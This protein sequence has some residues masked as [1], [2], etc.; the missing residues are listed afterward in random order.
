MSFFLAA[1]EIKVA[2]QIEL[3]IQKWHKEWYGYAKNYSKSFLLL[4]ILRKQKKLKASIQIKPEFELQKC[5]TA[6][7]K[8]TFFPDSDIYS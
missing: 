7:T 2:N 3:V 4:Y 8:M 1:P 5:F 6:E